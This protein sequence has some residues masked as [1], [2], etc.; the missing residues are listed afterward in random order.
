MVLMP[1][2]VPDTENPGKMLAFDEDGT[3]V[4]RGTLSVPMIPT[5]PGSHIVNGI[6]FVTDPSVDRPSTTSLQYP[7]Q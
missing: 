4:A 1:I 5:G 6:N 2:L 3:L 7:V